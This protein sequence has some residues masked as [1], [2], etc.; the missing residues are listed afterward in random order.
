[1]SVGLN[2][3]NHKRKRTVDYNGRPLSP[4]ASREENEIQDMQKKV[5]I[6]ERHNYI[7]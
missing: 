6:Y 4:I 5:N 1:V 3:I 2:T 7:R